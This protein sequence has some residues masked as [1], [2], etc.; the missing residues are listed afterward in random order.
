MR[1]QRHNPPNGIRA[2]KSNV[3]PLEKHGDGLVHFEER[4]NTHRMCNPNEQVF[5]F[6]WS[7]FNRMQPSD[8][9]KPCDHFAG[10]SWEKDA[11]E[12]SDYVK[13]EVLGF[14]YVAEDFGYDG[15]HLCLGGN[16]KTFRLSLIH[17]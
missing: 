5:V 9:G 6:I 4:K 16:Y 15:C 13:K 3:G 17:I 11:T 10:H 1:S 7:N 2:A 14:Q 12:L 8:T